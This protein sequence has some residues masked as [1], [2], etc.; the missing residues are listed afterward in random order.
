MQIYASTL[1]VLTST[2]ESSTFTSNVKQ[3]FCTILILDI[4]NVR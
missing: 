4:L 1:Q 3:V 2:N